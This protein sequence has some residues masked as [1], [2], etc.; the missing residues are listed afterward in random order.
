[1]EVS[2]RVNAHSRSGDGLYEKVTAF[3]QDMK[4]ISKD[5]AFT[6]ESRPKAD[7]PR[8]AEVEGRVI[9]GIDVPPKHRRG[10]AEDDVVLVD[11]FGEVSYY[12]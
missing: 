5:V 4:T 11:V 9:I 7:A 10:L 6:H 2:V 3:I 1:M 8:T 12:V